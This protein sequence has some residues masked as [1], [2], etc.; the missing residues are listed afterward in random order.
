MRE[1]VN[2][3]LHVQLLGAFVVLGSLGCFRLCRSQP[4]LSTIVG[5][6]CGALLGLCGYVVALLWLGAPSAAD[7]R[8]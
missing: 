3:L 6:S 7:T 1:W 8:T 2:G 4:S 5:T